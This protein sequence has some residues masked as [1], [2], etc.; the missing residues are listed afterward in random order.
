MCGDEVG[1]GEQV[2]RGVEVAL[3]LTSRYKHLHQRRYLI[4]MRNA[5]LLR[6]SGIL[7][8]VRVPSSHRAVF[9]NS[10]RKAYRHILRRISGYRVFS[11][12]IHYDVDLPPC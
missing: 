9:I 4:G 3:M 5:S 1:G 7:C 2:A 6:Y 12:P 10:S 11:K 8:L